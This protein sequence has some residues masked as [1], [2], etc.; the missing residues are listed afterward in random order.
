[1]DIW[2]TTWASR[3][4]VNYGSAP[5]AMAQ[6]GQSYPGGACETV[7]GGMGCRASEEI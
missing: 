2:T 1:V 4:A 6:N 5:A 7:N 3:Q